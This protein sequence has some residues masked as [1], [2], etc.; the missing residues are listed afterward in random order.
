MARILALLTSARKKGFTSGLLMEAL[1]GAEEVEG[2]EVD[3]AYVYDYTFGPCTS[4]YNCI[5]EIGRYCT[6]KDD[7]GREGA[8]FQKILEA[9]A[10]IIAEPVHMWG[11]AAMTHLFMERLYPFLWDGKLSGM[12]FVSISCASNQGMMRI[13]N[14]DLAR[15]AFCYKMLYLGGL[16]VH[17]VYYDEGLR[18]AR[19]LGIKLAQAGLEDEQEGRRPLSDEEAWFYYMDKPWNALYLYID[20]LTRGT[21]RWE[22]SLI[23]Y[24][25]AQGVFKDEEAIQLMEEAREY[26]IQTINAWNLNDY[27]EAQRNLIEASARWTR[28][29]YL[30]FG[31]KSMDAEQ[32][33]LY[34]PIPSKKND[35]R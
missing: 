24:G 7:M 17:R 8:L 2:A 3:L 34:R 9:N 32:P 5:R 4:C 13:A 20:N 10:L 30:E 19:Y 26:M 23:E 31:K 15:L 22:D 14:R 25:L 1:T 27:G 18:H 6:L 11:N 21:F 12:P 33:E 35:E 16:P 29:T 28:A